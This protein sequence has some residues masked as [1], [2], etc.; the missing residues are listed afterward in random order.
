[1]Q[2]PHRFDDV[3]II[4]EKHDEGMNWRRFHLNRECWIFIAGFHAD[5]QNITEVRNAVKSF[6]TFMEWDQQLSSDAGILVKI[7]VEELKDVPSSILL[8]GTNEFRG[9][10]WA[11]PVS[12]LQ[13][14]LIE[15]G[16]ADEEPI[17]QDG[18]PHP[19]PEQPHFHPNQHHFFGPVNQHQVEEQ[20]NE[21]VHQAEEQN[22][23]NQVNLDL[24]LVNVPVHLAQDNG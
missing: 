20:N 14:K 13:Q 8:T 12:I 24:N 10:S 15:D 9:G 2:S 17:P 11:C 19:I 23:H 6:S 21:N 16:P 7:R 22:N 3:H 5:L 1:M 18:N 4:F